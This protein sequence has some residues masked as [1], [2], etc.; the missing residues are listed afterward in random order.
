MLAPG[1]EW[2]LFPTW[3]QSLLNNC[4]KWARVNKVSLSPNANFVLL[5]RSRGNLRTQATWSSSMLAADRSGNS[6]KCL[7]ISMVLE[8]RPLSL[9][10]I[11]LSRLQSF[12]SKQNSVF[13]TTTLQLKSEASLWPTAGRWFTGES[14]IRSC[15]VVRSLQFDSVSC[16]SWR[17]NEIAFTKRV[18]ANIGKSGGYWEIALAQMSQKIRN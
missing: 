4:R 17:F 18:E 1:I 13:E 6:S 11:P 5:F 10:Q 12:I 14:C 15:V 9:I 16:Q 2:K 8:I 3:V 7:Q